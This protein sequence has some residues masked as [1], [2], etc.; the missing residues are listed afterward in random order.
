[1]ICLPVLEMSNFKRRKKHHP[2]TC[3]VDVKIQEEK[4]KIICLPDLTMSSLKRRKK[5]DLHTCF[6][7]VKFQEEKER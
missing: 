5:D 3:F 7:D 1:M 4:E 6:D 2:L